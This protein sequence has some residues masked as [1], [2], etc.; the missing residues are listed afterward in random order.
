MDLSR[1]YLAVT[2][3]LNSNY[4]HFLFWSREVSIGTQYGPI[5]KTVSVDIKRQKWRYF[6]SKVFF[7]D[8]FAYQ[9]YILGGE[10]SFVLALIGTFNPLLFLDQIFGSWIFIKNFQTFLEVK[11]GINHDRFN[12]TP[13][14]AHRVL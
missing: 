7:H 11:I 13:C 2:I 1:I 12:L 9:L 6:K 14:Q 10:F 8:I 4:L 3:F 5:S